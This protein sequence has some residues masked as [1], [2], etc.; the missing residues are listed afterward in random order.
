M[1]SY[2]DYSHSGGLPPADSPLYR[3]F[4]T[5][6]PRKIER[7]DPPK[8]P[9]TQGYLTLDDYTT[10]EQIAEYFRNPPM[11]KRH[12]LQTYPKYVAGKR[13]RTEI[14]SKDPYPLDPAWVQA[15]AGIRNKYFPDYRAW[16]R[17]ELKYF[18]VFVQK[19]VVQGNYGSYRM[20]TSL[21]CVASGTGASASIGRKIHCRAIN[22]RI[23]LDMKPFFMSNPLSLLDNVALNIFSGLPVRIMIVL[24]TQPNGAAAVYNGIVETQTSVLGEQSLVDIPDSMLSFAFNDLNTKRFRMIYD[25]QHKI[26][27]SINVLP[28]EESIVTAVPPAVDS[29]LNKPQ[30]MVVPKRQYIEINKPLNFETTYNSNTGNRSISNITSNNLLCFVAPSTVDDNP[31]TTPQDAT[32]TVEV[33]MLSRLRFDD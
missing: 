32:K 13:T 10:K 2:R 6:K 14:V 27:C 8:A 20:L 9:Y 28:D 11:K 3:L 26:E 25:A 24:D 31:I 1:S 5:E 19:D 18:D 23:T 15:A 12:V 17:N 22:M 4:F 7:L 29:V 30:L 21:N 33:Q 16:P